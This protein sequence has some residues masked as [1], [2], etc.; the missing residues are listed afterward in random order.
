[1]AAADTTTPSTIPGTTR[2]QI[3]LGGRADVVFLLRDYFRR[4]GVAAEVCGPTVVELASGLSRADLAK[5]LADWVRVMDV[6]AEFVEQAPA[7]VAIAAAPRPGPRLGSLLTAKGFITEE[8][9]SLALNESRETREMLGAL[10]LRKGWIFEE[11]LART[12]SEQLDVPYLSVGR[13]GV[14]IEVAQ[15]LPREVGEQVAAIPVRSRRGGV[16]V[17]FADPTDPTAIEAVEAYIEDVHPAV[18]EFSDIR[19]AWRSVEPLLR[20]A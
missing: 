12:L 8:Q 4:L 2:C 9:L 18:A 17:A 15:L 14:N 6:R 10:L 7:R 20:I 1:V 13:V 19:L 3:T 5:F 11:E 16:Q